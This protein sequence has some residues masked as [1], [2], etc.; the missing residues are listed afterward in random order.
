MNEK[1]YQ[2]FFD[3]QKHHWWFVAK[4]KIVVKFVSR[5]TRQSKRDQTILDV[6]CGAGLMLTELEKFGTVFGMDFSDE[7][8][9]FSKKIFKGDV[10][11]GSLPSNV[12]FSKEYFD[13][14]TALDVIEHID[15]DVEALQAL[16][17]LLKDN[18]S[19]VVTVPAYMFLWTKFDEINEHKRR[20]TLPELR[21]KLQFAGF[22]VDYIS[23]YNSFLFPL[24][25]AVRLFNKLRNNDGASELEVPNKFVNSFLKRVFMLEALVLGNLRFPFGVSIIAVAKKIKI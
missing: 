3:V 24:A 18:G 16:N 4:K 15:E 21:E 17:S 12:P 14:I 23:Y 13:L 7:A 6:G 9:S 22:S 8:V 10:R 5:I 2:M 1:M 20:Y 11:K 25:F 19:V